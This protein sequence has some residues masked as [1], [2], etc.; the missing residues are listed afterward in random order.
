MTQHIPED[1]EP[2]PEWTTRQTEVDQMTKE[3]TPSWVSRFWW[4]YSIGIG[5]LMFWFIQ[6][7]FGSEY[8]RDGGAA[9]WQC[10]SDKSCT[11]VISE[12]AD[13]VRARDACGTLTDADG[14][15]RY[16]R[17]N[18][19]AITK[20]FVCPAKPADETRTATCPAGTTGSWTQTQTYSSAP[21]PACW[22]ASG[23]L[24]IA[25]P[26]GSCV[27]PP[28]NQ[29][30][31]ISGTPAAA[32]QVG[33]MYS[34]T[35]TASDPE[36][37]TLTFSIAN[38]PAWATFNTTSGTLSGAP[39]ASS[40]GITS[41][42]KITVSDG[43]LSASTPVFSITVT[44]APAP[45]APT[46]LTGTMSQN[47]ANPANSNVSLTWTAVAG[48]TTYEV[49]R[50]T[51]ATCTNFAFL[52][53][54]TTA[55]YVNSNLPPNL[56]YRYKVRAWKPATGAYSGI[57]GITTTATPPPP[58]G[59]GQASLKWTPPTKNTDGTTLSDLAGYRIWYG[60]LADQLDK[61]I[62]VNNPGLAAYVVEGLAPG[63]WYFAVAAYTTAGG[64]SANSNVVSKIVQ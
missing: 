39:V 52:A 4:L 57:F 60:S 13:A 23:H 1:A 43:K 34:F 50:C 35:P 45:G 62:N 3:E 42:I 18:A 21:A 36:G 29:A 64:E 46:N 44:A 48:V 9:D 37:D 14:V 51:G 20:P 40:V 27:A 55:S 2:L 15:T 25:P 49:W 33:A 16:T 54:T 53:D 58:V 56:S 24:P 31:S 47:A 59:T 6:A 28:V 7:A 41:S 10:C 8:A 30:P 12:H 38:K 5:L 19:F 17:S 63:T 11:T 26:A 22:V 32:V 61:R